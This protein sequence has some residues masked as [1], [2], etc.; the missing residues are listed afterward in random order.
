M[1]SEIFEFA[2]ENYSTRHFII[3]K[4]QKVISS[5][6][7]FSMCVSEF[8]SNCKGRELIRVHKAMFNC[9]AMDDKSQAEKSNR[10]HPEQ[11]NIKSDK[12]SC[13]KNAFVTGAYINRI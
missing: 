10:H 3:T 2:V 9:D 12:H 5:R 7:L 11:G 1:A 6:H 13:Y 4:N 8:V